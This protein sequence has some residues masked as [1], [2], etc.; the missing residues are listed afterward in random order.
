MSSRRLVLRTLNAAL[1]VLCM[2]VLVGPANAA[3]ALPSQPA[4]VT[5]PSS[6]LRFT[7]GGHA[8]GFSAQSVYAASGTHALH[9]DFLGANAV[10]PQADSLA[11][12]DG[13]A[14][15]LSRVTYPNLWDGVSLTFTASAGGIYSTTYTLA[16]GADARNIRLQYNAPLKLN[17]NGTLN[18]AFQTG[19]MTETAPVAWQVIH[20]RRAPV[21]VSF[22]VRGQQLSFALGA[23]DP[24][25]PLMIDPTL[26]WHTF[27][28]GGGDDAA[29][30]IAVDGSGN[31]YAAGQSGADWDSPVRPYTA[32]S[33]AF[34]AAFD[35][36]GNLLWN[37]F[38]GGTA[39]DN[40]LGIAVDGSGDVYV[41]G[42]SNATWG[43]PLR[44][45]SNGQ[46]AFVAKVDSSGALLWNTFLGAAG[47]D[48][49]RGITV[50]GG[51]DV[52]VVGYSVNSWG[53]PVRAHSAG[54]NND[55]FTAKL[56][57]LGALT[58]NTFQGAGGTDFSKSVVVDGGGNVFVAG[59]SSADWGSPVWPHLGGVDAFVVK[60][61]SAGALTWLA[62][63]GSASDDFGKGIALDGAGDVYVSGSS[64]AS[65][66][67]SP[68]R[69]YSG[70]QDA[71]AAKLMSATGI[72]SWNTFLGGGGS[73]LAQGLGV[74]ASGNV[75]VAGWS[76]ATWGSPL[77]AYSGN[78]DGFTTQLS[79][80]GGLHF[81]TFLG[82]TAEDQ[83]TA[84]AVDGFGVGYV[85][86]YS[87][88]SWG[89]PVWAYTSGVDG[90]AAKVDFPNT[91]IDTFISQGANDGWVLESG[92][93]TNVG[94]S[95]N[96]IATTFRVGD[97]A[98]DKQYR[99]IVSFNTSSL[100]DTAV[101]TKATLKVRQQGVV[102]T[103]PFS[104]HGTL[105]A[106]IRTPYFGTSVVLE[107][108]D[109]QATQ[110]AQLGFSSTPVA[111]WYSA[112]S[113]G[114]VSPYINRTGTT[115]FRLRF[116]LDDNDDLAA[117]Y[118]KFYSGNASL[119]YRPQLII[120][121]YVP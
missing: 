58:W 121:Y 35:S 72:R 12:S 90:F 80:S 49:G 61:S 102:G 96:S 38:L 18:I 57:S 33:D 45:Y 107:S 118:V 11:R 32:G 4:G 97:E 36:S 75:Y 56:T 82:G 62:F 92:E 17:S 40:G 51:P 66:G 48:Q 46:D 10:Q 6:L 25:Y 91:V 63:M 1:I 22:R 86:G 27:M 65:W 119:I 54:A 20:G 120:E 55:G 94:G 101:I 8:L 95:M 99:G 108:I 87:G 106:G 77:R 44:A 85:A 74:D 28:G 105:L 5:Q 113:G 104:T 100:P 15:P 98:G 60:L 117:D 7:S 53:A 81:S 64:L 52:Y 88:S 3:P 16:P 110:S 116:T 24:R 111:N 50:D 2:L 41:T 59:N 34:A 76:S 103:I 78:L 29:W 115:Q 43:T 112:I 79:S 89:N 114:S 83:A 69:A 109:F 70:G 67:S 39:Y 13:Q 14:A 71:F 68:V 93:N 37:T 9:L 30:A 26:V 47:A 42:H 21:Q 84:M 19:A 23:Y 73:D 31:T